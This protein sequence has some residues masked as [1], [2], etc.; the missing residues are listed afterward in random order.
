MKVYNNEKAIISLTSW[1]KRINTTAITVYSLLKNCPGFHI[2]LV[3]SEDEF[4]NKENDLPID[5]LKIINNDLI[6]LIWVKENYMSFK[7]VLFTMDKYRN[8]PV[9]SADDGDFYETN[10]AQELYNLWEKEK[11]T[12]FCNIYYDN[13]IAPGFNTG[14]GVIFPPYCF[15]DVGIKCI[16]T[17]MNILKENSNDDRFL[18]CLC[19]KLNLKIKQN[20]SYVCGKKTFE[21][22]NAMGRLKLFIPGSNWKFLELIDKVL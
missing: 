20:K 1:K 9:I 21:F 2:V 10:Y 6:E 5:L 3:L 11:D 7:K 12:I 18:A 16:T 14:C 8:V 15:K 19:K 4:T 13:E 22:Q 17:F